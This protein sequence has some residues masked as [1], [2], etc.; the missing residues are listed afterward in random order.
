[1]TDE[2][3]RHHPSVE[4]YADH[5]NPAFVKLL[6]TFGYGRV[7]VR[8]KGAR[9]WDDA[10]REYV[11]FL[12]A[13]GAMNL[14]HNPPAL[15]AAMHAFLDDEMVNL[16]HVGPQIH[17][18]DLAA[19]L[20]A[21]TGGE[22]D[23]AMFSLSGSEAVESAIKLARAA[24]GRTRVL[25]TKNA[26]HG[27]G[28][29]A[30]SVIGHG[31]LRDPFEPLLPECGEIPFDDLAALEA[32]LGAHRC[33]C[34]IVEPI[35]AEAG[36]IVPA[37]GYLKEAKALC[38]K[39]GALF[40]LDEAQTGMGRTGSMFAFEE[41]GLVPDV[42]LLG[43][44]LGAG[45]VPISC[46]LAKRKVHQKAFGSA[47]RFDLHGSTYAANAL[48]CRVAREILRL[49]SELDLS[50][51]A[52][53]KGER[54]TRA[55]AERTRGHPFVR[56]IRGRGLLVGV[57]LGPT[58]GGGLLNRLVP[59][60]VDALSRKVFGQWLSMRLL[61]RGILAQPASQQWNVLK[62]QPPLDV[63][64]ADLELVVRHTGEILDQYRELLPLV[65]DVG[66]RL[67]KQM[68]GGWSF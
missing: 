27:N 22:L 5:V 18:G 12:S 14:G 15:I 53:R 47:E 44:G 23:V 7:F 20:A 36:V 60:L 40:V 11:D 9:L 55:L 21:L 57:E 3:G 62:L 46:A 24:T 42:L 45:L 8:A 26:F 1:M 19:E 61:E 35:Q 6:G 68:R 56:E 41:Q 63:D 54:L 30:L 37:D 67:G 13:F 39:H 58:E 17:A 38:E 32:G 48:S 16:V 43:K 33:A 10:G 4:R 31:R 34:F 59:G 52:R 25:Y 65:R 28:L 64:D 29:G 2:R 50:G 49:T 66:E 51:Q